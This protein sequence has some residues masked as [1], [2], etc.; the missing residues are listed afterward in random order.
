MR[1]PLIPAW[2]CSPANWGETARLLD[3][4]PQRNAHCLVEPGDRRNGLTVKMQSN[5]IAPKERRTESSCKRVMF[6]S[7]SNAAQ[8]R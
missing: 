3:Q 8:A 7:I 2:S 4:I 1:F 5:H 6:E